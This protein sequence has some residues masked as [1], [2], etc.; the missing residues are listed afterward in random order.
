[1]SKGVY[2]ATIEPHSG[3]SV[4]TLGLI[5]M[6][7]NHKGCVGYFKPVITGDGG[8]EKDSHLQVI[9]KHFG[10]PYAYEEL[11]GFTRKEITALMLQNANS[12]IIETLIDKYKRME[13]KCDYTIVEGTDFLGKGAVFEFDANVA[14]AKNFGIPA[15]I[16]VS[17]EGKTAEELKNNILAAYEGFAKGDVEVLAVVANKVRREDMSEIAPLLHPYLGDQAV[18]A[19]I[20]K[21]K[22]LAS[23]TIREINAGLGA[24]SLFGHQRQGNSVDHVIVG[25]M[26]LP[27]FLSYIQDNTLVVTP[28]TGRTLSSAPSRPI[29]PATI[30]AWPAFFLPAVLSLMSQ[31]SSLSKVFRTSYPS[32]WRRRGPLKRPP[33]SAPYTRE[34]MPG[35]QRK[36]TW[37]S[38]SSKNMWTWKNSGRRS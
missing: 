26:Q 3:K 24:R 35:I 10:L 7:L 17:G 19:V 5:N 30:P 1:M 31:S 20:P 9:M 11:F 4:V 12:R 27:H 28:G 32:A 6:I 15:I 13:E 25:A 23:P 14:V 33:A 38:A 29:S 18:I 37:R 34:S 2:V 8:E 16:V 22:I 21:N 36:S